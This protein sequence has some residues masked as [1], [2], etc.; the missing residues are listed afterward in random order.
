[1]KKTLSILSILIA[2]AFCICFWYL[3]IFTDSFRTEDVLM[4]IYGF[5][6]SFVATH[7]ALV[8]TIVWH[9]RNFLVK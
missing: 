5:V 1:M 9:K 4:D 3:V 2:C 8:G 7:G 6:G